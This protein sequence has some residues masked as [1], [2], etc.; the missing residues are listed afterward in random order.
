LPRSDRVSPLSSTRMPRSKRCLGKV[1]PA[2][3][4]RSPHPHAYYISL[5]QPQ[6]HMYSDR[7]DYY[8]AHAA[9]SL[10]LI[11]YMS[12]NKSTFTMAPREAWCILLFNLRTRILTNTIV[13][14]DIT[15]H[16][17][18]HDTKQ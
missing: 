1:V 18:I 7:N 5:Q 12:N 11:S 2:T 4:R 16:R 9:L 3:L 13:Q 8:A 14:S 6:I 15:E 17:I 10:P